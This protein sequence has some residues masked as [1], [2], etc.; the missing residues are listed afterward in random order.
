MMKVKG[1]SKSAF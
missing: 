1:Q